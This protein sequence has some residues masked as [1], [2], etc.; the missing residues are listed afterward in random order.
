VAAPLA[1][2]ATLLAE[3]CTSCHGLDRVTSARKEREEWAQVIARMAGRGAELSEAEQAVL[4][5]YLAQ[6]Y[7]P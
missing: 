3:R 4:L 2:G 6:T 1:D 7:G 5:D